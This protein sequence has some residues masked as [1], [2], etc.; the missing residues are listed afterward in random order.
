MR[1]VTRNTRGAE[2]ENLARTLGRVYEG[3]TAS[4]GGRAKQLGCGAFVQH[5]GA[6][7]LS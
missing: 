4:G 1:G 7:L 2:V 5:L 6:V 3:S